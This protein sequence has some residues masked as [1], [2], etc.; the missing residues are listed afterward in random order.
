MVQVH[1]ALIAYLQQVNKQMRATCG[2]SYVEVAQGLSGGYG[3]LGD[4]MKSGKSATAFVDEVASLHSLAR[5][6]TSSVGVRD[7]NIRRAAIAEYVREADGWEM[8]KDGAAYSE[9]DAGL[10]RMD[11]VQSQR[12]GRWGFAISR[13]SEG[14]MVPAKDDPIG[15]RSPSGAEFKHLGAAGDI[16]DAVS[17][18]TERLSKSKPEA[19]P[20]SSTL[21]M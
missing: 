11:V 20:E 4:A 5:A 2:V 7:L 14:L 19:E 18:A 12:N 21:R 9:T 15:R 10:L 3:S 13:S 8:G 6:D 16:G 17:L 1:P